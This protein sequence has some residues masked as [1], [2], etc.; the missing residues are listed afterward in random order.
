MS[1]AIIDVGAGNLHSVHKA[2]AHVLG[3]RASALSITQNPED[4]ANASRIILP[5]VGAF[6]DCMAGLAAIA[7]MRD[8]LEDAVLTRHVPFLGI[9]V[10]MQMLFAKSNEHGTHQGLGWLKGH[11]APLEASSLPIPHMGWNQLRSAQSTH[12][13]LQHLGPEPFAYFV[14]SYHA[15]DIAGDSLLASVDYEGPV[16]AMVGQKN[17]L[18]MQFHPE[19]S[20]HVGLQL[21]RNFIAW[22]P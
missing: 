15:C 16:V 13:M 14:H 6:G 7:G 12:P 3:D 20:G 17:I 21:L 18:G 1:I 4:L 2:F 5:G 11:V 22:Q 8:A 19:K 10:G 9:C